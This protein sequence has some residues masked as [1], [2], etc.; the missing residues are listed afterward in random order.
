MNYIDQLKWRYA[1]KQFDTEKK[2][3]SDTW[4]QIEESLVLTPSS[5]GLQPW[6]FAVIT[7]E[8]LRAT[9]KGHSW[10]QAQVTDCSHFVVFCACENVGEKEINSFLDDMVAT[11]GGTRE[12]L[13]FYQDMMEG[14]IG[15]MSDVEKFHWATNQAYIA[16][17]QLMATAAAL[18]IDACPMEGIDPAKYDEILNIEGYKTVV[19]CALGFRTEDDKYASLPKVRFSKDAVI[20]RR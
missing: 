12:D 9:L 18:E 17:G 11:R 8:A 4:N 16:I 1:T 15:K 13:K 10:D 5:F 3:D 2:I 14:F 6:K 20:T 7:D 19:A